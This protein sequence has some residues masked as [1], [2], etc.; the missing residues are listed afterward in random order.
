VFDEN[1]FIIPVLTVLENMV[2]RRIFGPKSEEVTGEWRKLQN[3]KLNDL[4][5]SSIN[6]R[7][8]H[9]R[10]MRWAGYVARMIVE[11]YTGFWWGNR[12]ESEHLE[13][14]H[15]DGR[16]ILRRIFRK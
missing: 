10:R 4:Y 13:N 16:I 1:C 2:L 7:V 11:V 14:P 5:S 8:I 3:G 12:R 6:F 15:V 9:S